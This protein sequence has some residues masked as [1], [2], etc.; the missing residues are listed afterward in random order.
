[1]EAIEDIVIVGAG[2]AGLATALG[3]HRV[4][5]RSLILESSDRLRITGF[6]FTTW[7]NA[8]KALDALGIGDTLRQEHVQ[9]RR[10]HV[11]SSVTGLSASEISFTKGEVRCL[12]RKLLLETLE[13]ELPHGTI[14]FDSKVVLVEKS[15]NLQLVHLADGSIIKTKILI[16]SDG[17]N[18][19]IA[20]SLGLRK[21]AF[22]G[23]S[24]VRGVA[25]FPDGHDLKP[26][27]SQFV[28][29]GF[30]S[31]FIPCDDKTVYWFF[32]YRTSPQSEECED[33]AKKMK[34]Y[35]LS[36]LGKVPKEMMTIVEASE[37]ETVVSAPLTF[38]WPWELLWGSICDGNI[39]VTGDALHPMTPDLG[40][41]ACSALE[42]AITL[43]RCLGEA[44]LG[45]PRHGAPNEEARIK[46]ALEK[47]AKERR[48]R[49]INLISTSY[50][51]GLIQQSDNRVMSFFRDK[52]LAGILAGIMLRRSDFDCGELYKP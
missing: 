28:G 20:K 15:G 34:P 47:F 2:I 13:R 27:M 10:L 7:K 46:N 17:V 9:L 32:T 16:G 39:C 3:L 45:K 25:E 24:A 26:E 37:L 50:V 19:I 36:N 18:S 43:A 44:F 52:F 30:R 42:D 14:R 51:T 21:P 6:A 1:M 38:R 40:Q 4:G 33:D 29:N 11:A 41:G 5:L 8:W 31:G 48:W 35:I 49:S 12:R 23:R 22:T